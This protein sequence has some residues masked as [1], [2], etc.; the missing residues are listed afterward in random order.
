MTAQTNDIMRVAAKLTDING[1][2]VVNVFHVRLDSGGPVDDNDIMIEIGNYMEVIYTNIVSVLQVGMDFIDI[3]FFNVT[4]DSPLGSMLWPNLTVG[5]GT[6]DPLPAQ[7][8][9]M[10]RGTTGK[11]RNWARKFFGVFSE[12]QNTDDGKISGTVQTAL[13]NL[14]GDWLAGHTE[15]SNTY[16]PVVWHAKDQLWRVITGGVVRNIWSTIRRRR[17]GRGI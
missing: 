13:T 8:A 15:D 3:N 17:H 7:V 5:S 6:G 10:V 9:A 4:Q 2:A 12:S 11:S 16:V 14:L 1:D